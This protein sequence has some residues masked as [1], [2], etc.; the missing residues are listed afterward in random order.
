M[1]ARKKQSLSIIPLMVCSMFII[2]CKSQPSI[3]PDTGTG[4]EAVRDDLADL[5]SGQT[6]LAVTGTKIEDGSATVESGLGDL[7]QS[8]I[9]GTAS[10]GSFEEIIREVRKRPLE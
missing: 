5:T 9:I 2:N 1:Y 10:N 4:A 6:E 7:E 8:I 3:I